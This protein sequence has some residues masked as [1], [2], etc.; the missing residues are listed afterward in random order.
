MLYTIVYVV[1]KAILPR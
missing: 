1:G